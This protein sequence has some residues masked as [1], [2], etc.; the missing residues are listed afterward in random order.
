[1]KLISS[2]GNMLELE[3]LGYQFP[4]AENL[5]QRY[6]WLD[7]KGKARSVRGEWSFRWFALGANEG[8]LIADWLDL[9]VDTIDSGAAKMEKWSKTDFTEPNLELELIEIQGTRAIIEVGLGLE[10]APPWKSHGRVT[11]ASRDTMRL[12]LDRDDLEK[13]SQEWRRNSEEFPDLTPG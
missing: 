1:M 4:E 12:I 7:I 5:S 11:E 9:V 3:I 10:F 8:E 6:S 2:N 13:A